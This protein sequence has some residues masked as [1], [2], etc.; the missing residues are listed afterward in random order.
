VPMRMLRRPVRNINNLRIRD[1]YIRMPITDRMRCVFAYSNLIE[2]QVKGRQ[3][4]VDYLET[5]RQAYSTLQEFGR[6]QQP[7]HGSHT[8]VQVIIK[9]HRTKIALT[10]FP[11][12]FARRSNVDNVV[13]Y[14]RQS[15]IHSAPSTPICRLCNSGENT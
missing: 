2:T 1:I 14:L 15:A 7:E 4:F 13:L 6:C 10:S 5:S 11:S 8:K 12:P 9:K 3:R